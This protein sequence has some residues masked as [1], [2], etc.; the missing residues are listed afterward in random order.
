MKQDD[1]WCKCFTINKAVRYPRNHFGEP[2]LSLQ[3]Q[4]AKKYQFVGK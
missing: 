3:L 2:L 4:T 1:G